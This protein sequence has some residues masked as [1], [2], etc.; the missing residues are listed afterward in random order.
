M[1]ALDFTNPESLIALGAVIRKK[2]ESIGWTQEKLAYEAGYS[3]KIIRL[4][5]H[6]ARTKLKTLQDVC[7]ALGLPSDAYNISENKIADSRY[8][9]YNLTHYIDYIGVYFAFRRGFTNQTNFLRT[10]FE[11]AWSDEKRCLEFY[12]DHKYTSSV[13]SH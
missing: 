6:G 13:P 7:Q 10:I 1:M 11:I 12:E 2:R 3:D 9:S 4:I 8:G 5:E